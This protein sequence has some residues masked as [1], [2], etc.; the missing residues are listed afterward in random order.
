M[1]FLAGFAGKDTGVIV[2]VAKNTIILF[3]Q[4]TSHSL[5]GPHMPSLMLKFQYI[6]TKWIFI[7][8]FRNYFFISRLS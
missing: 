8:I 7:F 1:L 5:Q 2:V 4:G 3:C 6:P